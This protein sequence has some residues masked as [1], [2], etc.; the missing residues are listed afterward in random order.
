M[1]IKRRLRFHI[2]FCTHITVDRIDALVILS[3]IP[4]CPYGPI[5]EWD[6][7]SSHSPFSH[8]ENEQNELDV[9]HASEP[10]QCILPWLYAADHASFSTYAA[11]HLQLNSTARMA[12]FVIGHNLDILLQWPLTLLHCEVTVAN[13]VKFAPSNNFG[14]TFQ[15]IQ[16][17]I[18]TTGGSPLHSQAMSAMSLTY[19]LVLHQPPE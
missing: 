14:S 9:S 16:K 12:T 19:S 6:S 18:S 10:P 7:L 13:R 11:M 15:A 2:F 3:V 1:L 8:C 4:T 5:L 17:E